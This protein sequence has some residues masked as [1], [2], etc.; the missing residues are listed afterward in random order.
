[1]SRLQGLSQT[2][3]SRAM[4]V[5]ATHPTTLSKRISV[6]LMMSNVAKIKAPCLLQQKG[7][8]LDF[9]MIFL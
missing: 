3:M 1:M 7:R 2:E 5:R 8:G 6:A 4:T 9:A